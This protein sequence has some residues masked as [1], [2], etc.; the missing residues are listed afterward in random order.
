MKQKSIS[1]IRKE[2]ARIL[3]AAPFDNNQRKLALHVGLDPGQLHRVRTGEN[4][5][6][7][8]FV[9]RLCG[10]LPAQQSAKLFTAFVEDLIEVARSAEPA[11]Q[12]TAEWHAPL[13]DLK[14]TFACEV[15]DAA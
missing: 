7:A 3:R 15:R 1:R 8:E 5:A 2:I 4:V 11:R 10:A 14:I 13:S 6:T 12:P 9:G